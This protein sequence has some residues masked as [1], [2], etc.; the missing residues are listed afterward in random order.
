[1]SEKEEICGICGGVLIKDHYS[2]K[3]RNDKKQ[4]VIYRCS[5][6]GRKRF[7]DKKPRL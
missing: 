1:M 4:T 2:N 3:K 5:K 6:C 7:R